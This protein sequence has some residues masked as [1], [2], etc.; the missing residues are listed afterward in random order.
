M[1]YAKALEKAWSN[2][3]DLTKDE[4]FSVKFMSDSYK[5]T[6]PAKFILSARDLVPAKTHLQII[7]LHYLISKL[8]KNQLPP[9]TGEWIDFNQLEGGE[10]YYPIFR[11]RTIDVILKKYGSNPDALLNNTIG[12]FPAEKAGAGD[13]GIAIRPFDGVNIMI[14]VWKSDE[15]FPPDANILF[16]KNISGIFCTEDVV[17]LTESIVHML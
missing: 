1:G 17:V 12:K 9:P 6:V 15:E 14:T 3:A 16:D 8:S 11:K 13:T 10:V 5:I 2:I 4:V 7:I